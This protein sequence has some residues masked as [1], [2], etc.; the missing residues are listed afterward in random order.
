MMFQYKY[1]SICLANRVFSFVVF[2]PLSLALSDY[3]KQLIWCLEKSTLWITYTLGIFPA[4]IS[5]FLIARN[6]LL[7]AN[8]IEP[9]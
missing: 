7:T 5:C 3:C 1:G 2:L 4:A 9:N 8:K 6:L